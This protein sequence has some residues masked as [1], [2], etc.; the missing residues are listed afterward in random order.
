MHCERTVLSRKPIILFVADR[1]SEESIKGFPEGLAL[2][3]DLTKARIIIVGQN[4]VFPTFDDSLRFLDRSQLARLNRVMYEAKSPED[5]LHQRSSCGRW[6]RRTAWISSIGNRWCARRRSAVRSSRAGRRVSL[7]AIR[8]TGAM[9]AAACSANSWSNDSA[10]YSHGFR[11]ARG[12]GPLT[13]R[14]IG[15][16]ELEIELEVVICMLS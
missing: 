3:R 1:W 14:A 15:G 8:I 4:A 5:V 12:R 16:L 13:N 2:L 11:S 10:I 7:H 6:R 9:K